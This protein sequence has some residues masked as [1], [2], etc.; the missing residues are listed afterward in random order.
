[1]DN[2]VHLNELASLPRPLY[3][4]R[5]SL[6][7]IALD[8][9]HRHAWGQLSHALHGVLQV[10]TDNARLVV[11]PHRAVWIPPGSMH[12]VESTADACIRSL[13]ID[14]AQS[15]WP[16]QECRVIA[17]DPL[18]RELIRAFGELPVEYDQEAADGRLAQVLLDRLCLAE[19]LDLVLPQPRDPRLRAL[20]RQATARPWADIRLGEA[21]RKAGVSEKTF[22]RL[23]LKETGMTFRTWRQR[24]RLVSALPALERGERVTDVALACGYESLSAFSAAFARLFG[25]SP[26]ELAR[27]GSMTQA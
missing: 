12:R 5:D 2:I 6:P 17:V 27:G 16:G 3:G 10:H 13:Y 26:G 20:C 8:Y 19:Q 24:M 11:P 18:L 25:L 15:P 7:N 21:S 14:A 22:S 4:Q 9:R 23:F 1:M